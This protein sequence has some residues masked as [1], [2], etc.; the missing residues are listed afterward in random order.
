MTAIHLAACGG[1][2]TTVRLLLDKGASAE[3]KT[4]VIIENDPKI[5]STS[6]QCKP[7]HAPI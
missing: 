7:V 1:L 3:P 5:V 4:K 2:E 6:I